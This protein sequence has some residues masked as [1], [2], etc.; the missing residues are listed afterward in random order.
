MEW[1]IVYDF[2]KFHILSLEF[3]PISVLF[4]L[5]SLNIILIN[6]VFGNEG[7]NNKNGILAVLI[8]NVFQ[9]VGCRVTIPS[10]QL[11]AVSAQWGHAFPKCVEF[12]N[13]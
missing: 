5:K 1:W 12:G 8:K 2:N 4:R 6:N 3:I 7:E 13:V 11:D 10:P 9:R